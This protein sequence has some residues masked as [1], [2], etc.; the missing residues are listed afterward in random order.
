MN[1]FPNKEELWNGVRYITY[2]VPKFH[3]PAHIEVCN[4]LFSFN[5]T[6]V[7]V[8]RMERHQNEA[9]RT[10]TRLHTVQRRWGQEPVATPST[11][12]SGTGIGRKSLEW[13]GLTL[14][15]CAVNF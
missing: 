13:V 15:L 11:T 14:G 2:L 10:S 1:I 6:Q 7:L 4:L 12:T 9:G 5:L 8:G 3:L